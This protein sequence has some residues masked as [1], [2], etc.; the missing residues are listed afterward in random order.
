VGEGESIVSNDDVLGHDFTTIK[1]S[2]IKRTAPLAAKAMG[3]IARDGGVIS[4]NDGGLTS[5]E[6]SGVGRELV[7]LC[8]NGASASGTY[9]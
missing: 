9:S 7:E 4:S 1:T 3:G 6:G 5:P 8:L 2:P